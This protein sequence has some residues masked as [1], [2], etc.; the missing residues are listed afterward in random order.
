MPDVQRCSAVLAAD[1]P[2]Q[3]AKATAIEAGAAPVRGEV[4]QSIG[5]AAFRA[6]YGAALDPM[7][8]D[9]AL[10]EMLDHVLSITTK[11]VADERARAH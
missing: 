2:A 9:R 8:I 1:P 6:D 3:P 7:A 11:V 10:D 5:E 4:E